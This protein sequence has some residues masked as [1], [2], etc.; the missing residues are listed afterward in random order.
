MKA[1]SKKQGKAIIYCRARE[2]DQHDESDSL[3]AQESLCKIAMTNKHY[4]LAQGG[5]YYDAGVSALDMDRPGLQGLLARIKCDQSIDA[6]FVSGLERIARSVADHLKIKECFRASSVD[7]I[8]AQTETKVILM[9]PSTPEQEFTDAIMTSMARF[10]RDILSNKIRQ[11][12]AMKKTKQ[13]KGKKPYSC[14][15]FPS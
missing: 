3:S 12:I 9:L 6:V 8:C 4:E 1:G 15:C 5:L 7:L 11:R 10:Q 2:R 14:R 13:N